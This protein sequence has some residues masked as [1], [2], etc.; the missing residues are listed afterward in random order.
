[1]TSVTRR[2]FTRLPDRHENRTHIETKKRK[3]YGKRK[4][5]WQGN[6]KRTSSHDELGD[7]VDVV[8]ATSTEGS[9]GLLASAELLVELGEV[10]GG[11]LCREFGEGRFPCV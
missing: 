6:D 11:R 7:E 8:L 2:S 4:T 9:G 1:M 10:Q 3:L 5:A